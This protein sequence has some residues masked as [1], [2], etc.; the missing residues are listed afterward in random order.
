MKRSIFRRDRSHPEKTCVV[1]PTLRAAI[2]ADQRGAFDRNM[3]FA[4]PINSALALAVLAV[5]THAGQQA[6]AILWFA[7]AMTVNALRFG[8][9]L[10]GSDGGLDAASARRTDRL[11]RLSVLTAGLSGCVWA[12]LP[13]LSAFHTTPQTVFYLTVTCGVTAGSV[14]HGI[15]YARCP[16]AFITPPLLSIVAVLLLVEPGIDRTCLALTVLLYLAALIRSAFQSER[17]FRTASRLKHEARALAASLAD[18]KGR[19]VAVAEAMTRRAAHDPLTDLL[20]RAGFIEQVEARRVTGGRRETAVMQLDL[21]GFKAINDSLGHKAGDRVLVE[22]ASRIRRILPPDAVI[23][24]FGGDE[25]A[26]FW[27]PRRRGGDPLVLAERLIA[28]VGAPMA[29]LDA[30]RLGVSAGIRVARDTDVDDMLLS[31]DIALYEAKRT[32]RN[33]ACLFDETLRD[34]LARKRDIERDLPRALR[35]AALEVWFQP[36]FADGGRRMASFEALIRWTHPR[37]GRVPPPDIITGAAAAGASEALL[38]FILDQSCRMLADLDRCGRPDMEVAL[39]VSPREMVGT[40][41]DAIVLARLAADG[42]DPRRLAIEITEET[43]L[44]VQ[45]TRDKLAVLSA[46]GIRIAVDDFGVG[47]SSLGSLRHLRPHRVKIDRCFV[48]GIAGSS[49]DLT[50]VKAI[51]GLGR[52]LGF[53]VVAEGVETEADRATLEAAGCLTMQGFLLGRPAPAAAILAELGV[54]PLTAA[55]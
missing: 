27:D 24:R 28:S 19:A 31:A 32:G 53:E 16:I 34:E 50:L 1:S 37:H 17:V 33:R 14:T 10:I 46:A 8:V 26:V 51:L 23:A 41:V 52:E 22:V 15:A 30:T 21:D 42:L 49:E 5:A 38:R 6:F 13:L 25:F 55:A 47:Y 29:G 54:V 36:I 35:E 2:R 3:L 39:N 12:L 48:T 44:D 20:N 7:A 4:M 9:C 18:A 45:A 11:L 43:A 40:P